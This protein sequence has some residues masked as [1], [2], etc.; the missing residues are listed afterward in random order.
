MFRIVAA[1][2]IAA[3]LGAGAYLW[4]PAPPPFNAAAAKAAAGAYDVRI[5]R[6]RFGVPHIFG[7][8]DADV[9]FGLAYAHAEDDMATLEEVLFFVRSRLGQQTGK[10]GAVTDYLVYAL[11]AR[12]D[13]D[14]KYATD[15]S[16]ETRAVLEAYA[17]GINLYCAE[18]KGRCARGVAP[19]TGK[20]ILAGF[21]ARQPFFYG[22]EEKLTS[23]FADDEKAHAALEA[24]RTA[25]L[26]MPPGT[27]AGSNAMAVAPSRA[28]DGHTRL[29]VNSHQPY[30]GPV[31][32]YEAHL[33]SEEGWDRIGGV[34][35]GSPM[36]LH[37][38]GPD[39]GWAFTVNKPD[40]VDIYALEVDNPKK[41]AR[42]KFDGA[43]RD[44]ERATAKFRVKLLGP[45]SLPVS[46]SV[47]HSVHGPAFVT[48][49]GVFAVAFAGAGNVKAAEQ[50]F[51]M[52]KA[53]DFA[54]WREAMAIQGIPSL[55]AVYGDRAGT[56]AYFYNAAIPIRAARVDWSKTQDGSD[57]A[58]VWQGT[59]P[60]G[61]APFVVNPA[62]GYVVNA[63]NNPFEASAIEDSPK[64]ED[65][66]PEYGVDM[67]Q[68]N[69]GFRQHELFGEDA[70][71]T[72][73]EFVGYK[74]DDMYAAR[75]KLVAIID[76]LV[77]DAALAEN[78]ETKDAIA[79]L[80]TWD[81]SAA[82]DSRAAAL[83]IRIGCHVYNCYAADQP[84]DII[85]P[86][87]ALKASIREMQAA[88]GRLDPA[89]ADAMRLNRGDKSLPLDGG[90]DT[91]RAVY[92]DIPSRAGKWSAG[93]GDTYILYADWSPEGA[94]AIKTIH[95]FG[96]AT[97]DRSSPHYADQ[98][99]LFAEEQWKTPP[100]TLEAAL[101]EKTR[102]YRP[103]RTP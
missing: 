11:R 32:W 70:S 15:L 75:S 23:L 95:Q 62:S 74:M 66:P 57:P 27:E 92:P 96:S 46:R 77:A 16:A 89:W 41:P 22:L 98:A 8:R 36:I 84:G 20:D 71:I 54:A 93:G 43:W 85:D 6:D 7:K 63:N 58:L 34:F 45:F 25:F 94:V 65:F 55:H 12:E 3:L 80:A 35:P 42:Y 79:L 33:Q 103:G 61:S 14:A 39:N 60:F 53:R 49:K 17:A 28:A 72:A 101:A 81:R 97:L 99:P 29:M 64:A 5:V 67:R 4:T 9:A 91:L 26:D 87:E 78:P 76:G 44:F 10:P 30:T 90:P 18:E 102:D 59:R 100:L 19:V 38:A 40:L 86:V 88:F 37:G 52:N 48:P 73:E 69:R 47:L 24:A 31:A 13:V 21:V 51:R 82:R 2:M 83:A 56:I 1:L 68:S 50:Y